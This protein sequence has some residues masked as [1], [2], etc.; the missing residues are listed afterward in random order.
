MFVLMDS[1][2]MGPYEN[3]GRSQSRFSWVDASPS[4][5]IALVLDI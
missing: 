3:R 4:A 5:S 1:V 2:E